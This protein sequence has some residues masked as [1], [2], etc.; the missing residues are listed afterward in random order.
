MFVI[1]TVATWLADHA[2]VL[3]TVVSAIAAAV[4]AWFTV[5]LV[6]ATTGMLNAAGEQARL[7]RESIDLARDEYLA[8]HRP[9]I[10]IHTVEFAHDAM[11]HSEKTTVGAQISYVNKGRNSATIVEIRGRITNRTFPLQSGIMHWEQHVVPTE[12]ILTGRRG[13]IRI[14]SQIDPDFERIRQRS[15]TNP[16]GHVICIGCIVYEDDRGVRRETGF[17]RRLDAIAERWVPI[18]NSEYEYAY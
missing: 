7:T 16:R 3:A 14:S 13:Y 18:E 11:E 9:E 1:D 10:F 17:C 4:I 8:T 5:K 12:K 6:R 15:D 2:T